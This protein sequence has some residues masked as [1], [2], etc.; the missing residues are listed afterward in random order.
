MKKSSS[1][2]KVSLLTC[3]FLVVAIMVGTGVYTSLGIQLMSLSS[4]FAILAVWALGGIGALCGALSY[5]ELAAHLPESG[6]EYYYLS[7]IYHPSLGTMA[8]IITQTAAFAAPI[9]LASMA[10]GKYFEAIFP[11]ISPVISSMVLVT[12]LTGVHLVN[13]HCSS[14]FQ[15]II[16]GMKFLLILLILFLGFKSASGSPKMF[17]P[18]CRAVKELLH[19]SAGVALIFCFYAYSGWNSTTY[20]AG[21]VESAQKTVGRSLIIGTLIVIAIYLL[22]NAVFLM[23]APTQELK[24]VIN[25]GYVAAIHLLGQK[26]AVLMSSCIIVGL[27]AGVSGMIWVGPSIAQMMGTDLATLS[28]LSP[29]TSAGIPFRAFLLQYVLV[30]ILLST[31]SFKFILIASQF[32]L[33]LCELLGVIGVLVLRYKRKKQEPKEVSVSEDKVLF[34]CPLTPLPQII[35]AVISITALV[36]A[37]ITNPKEGMIGIAII[38]GSLAVYPILHRKAQGIKN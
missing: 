22:T 21:D 25:V 34:R 15:D 29:V 38:I 2:E 13:N 7:K 10:F 5:A 1:S 8:G 36:Y 24:G 17:L 4:G 32:P 27:I 20:M 14:L 19:P 12:L 28:W 35:F 30:M 6:G 18:S 9:S 31:A 37:M 3:I 26:G 23:A 16:T 11:S 33:I